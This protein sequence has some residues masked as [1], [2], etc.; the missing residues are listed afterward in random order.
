MWEACLEGMAPEIDGKVYRHGIE[1]VDDAAD[2]PE[3]GSMAT[4]EI[5]ESKAYDL[6]GRV[7]S[8][9][10]PRANSNRPAPTPESR[11]SNLEPGP[12]P[13]SRVSTKNQAGREPN[14]NAFSRSCRPG[15]RVHAGFD[16]GLDGKSDEIIWRAP[17]AEQR[18]PIPRDFGFA[19]TLRFALGRRTLQAGR[20]ASR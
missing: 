20:G 6:I 15:T 8:F 2:L 7:T 3:P 9:E 1:G 5:T 11:P 10:K 13:T 16:E 4:I 14:G 19:D 12:R 17:Q 18:F